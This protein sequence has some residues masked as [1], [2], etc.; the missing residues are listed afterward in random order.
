MVLSGAAAWYEVA[1]RETVSVD[2][3]RPSSSHF[4]RPPSSSF[5]SWCPY[6]L[7]YQYAYAAN[8][9][10]LPPYRTTV[11]SLLMPLSDS[12]FENCCWSTKSRLTASCR[13]VFQSSL[14][15]PSMWPTSY[16]LVS[17][18]TSTN[19]VLGAE[20][21]SCAHWAETSTSERAI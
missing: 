16:A 8:Q 4:L 3:G 12:S 1:G 2:S 18:S 13:S 9:L 21:L 6:S 11:S 20:R 19:T 10:L 5:T 7:K 14:T 17:S 15:A